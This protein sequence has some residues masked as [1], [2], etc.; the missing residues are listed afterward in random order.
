MFLIYDTDDQPTEYTDTKRQ[1]FHRMREHESDLAPTK[2][3]NTV[4][5]ANALLN[6][7]H[8]LERDVMGLTACL[9]WFRQM[10]EDGHLA[11]EAKKKV[12]ELLEHPY[13]GPVLQKAW[14]RD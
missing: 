12:Q 14:E 9:S 13:L 3:R 7:A 6:R 10:R 8:I 5:E 4:V 1:A 11:P 2:I